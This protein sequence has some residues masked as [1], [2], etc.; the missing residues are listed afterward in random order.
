[1]SSNSKGPTP[2]VIQGGCDRRHNRLWQILIAIVTMGCLAF[3]VSYR[4]AWSSLEEVGDLKAESRSHQN[5]QI[6]VTKRIDGTLI[7]IE[8]EQ[9]RQ[10]SML[11]DIWKKNGGEK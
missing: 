10:R 11:E 3:G 1:M 7:R 9:G 8:Q 6:E 4:V 2:S 5:S